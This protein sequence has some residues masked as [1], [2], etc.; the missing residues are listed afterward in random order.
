M[1]Q[2]AKLQSHSGI[3]FKRSARF[4]AD[5]LTG[6]LGVG[7]MVLSYSTCAVVLLVYVSSQVYTYSLMEDV[8]ARGRTERDLKEN[9]GLLT[10]RYANL[11]SIERISR[12]CE[13][14]LGMVPAKTGQLVRVSIDAEWAPRRREIEFGDDAG[15]VPGMT[16]RQTDEVT[17]VMR[18]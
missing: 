12:I 3:G 15:G 4:V 9:T 2:K 10:E 8:A 5:A 18:R 16:D 13:T 14:K 11:S 7:I 6:R 1:T 17:E